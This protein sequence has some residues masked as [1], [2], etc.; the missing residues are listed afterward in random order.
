[1]YLHKAYLFAV[2]D[3]PSAQVVE[4]MIL[5]DEKPTIHISTRAYGLLLTTYGDSYDDAQKKM[6]KQIRASPYW[7]W[8]K[9]LIK[10][11]G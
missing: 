3:T 11:R 1:M 8:V 7:I 9:P 5:S 2:I 10:R 4:V 6:V